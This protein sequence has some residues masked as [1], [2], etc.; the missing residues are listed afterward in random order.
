MLRGAL[1]V[2]TE[3]VIESVRYFSAADKWWSKPLPVQ[4]WHRIWPFL[5]ASFLRFDG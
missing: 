5:R 2:Q 3:L 1:Q 4:A